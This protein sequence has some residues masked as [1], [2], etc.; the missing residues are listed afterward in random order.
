MTNENMIIRNYRLSGAEVS[1]VVGAIQFAL[2][3]SS[4]SS[5]DRIVLENTRDKLAAPL[6]LPKEAQEELR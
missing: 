2:N 5:Y 1:R 4:W 6:N 3:R